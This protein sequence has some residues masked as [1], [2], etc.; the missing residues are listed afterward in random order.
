MQIPDALYYAHKQLMLQSYVPY[1][2]HT[3]EFVVIFSRDFIQ[4]P[5]IIIL[6]IVAQANFLLCR[7]EISGSVGK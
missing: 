5:D 7:E 2:I 1:Q 6:I 4:G 3:D